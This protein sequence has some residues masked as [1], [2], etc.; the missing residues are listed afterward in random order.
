MKRR[1]RWLSALFVS[2]FSSWLVKACLLT[3]PTS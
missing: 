2:S 1:A 3:T